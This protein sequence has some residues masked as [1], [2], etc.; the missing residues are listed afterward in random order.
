VF[1]VFLPGADFFEA[2]LLAVKQLRKNQLPA[3]KQKTP[4][5]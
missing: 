1:S 2:V 3:G 5:L 4:W